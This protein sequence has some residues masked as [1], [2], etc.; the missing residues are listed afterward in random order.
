MYL[1]LDEQ[2]EQ[3]DALPMGMNA[4]AALEGDS[5]SDSLACFSVSL[6]TLTD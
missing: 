1:D 2:P 5:M 3:S 6:E 4:P